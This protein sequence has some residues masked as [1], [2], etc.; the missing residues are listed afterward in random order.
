M[1]TKDSIAD[2][3]ALVVHIDSGNAQSL[4]YQKAVPMLLHK[5]HAVTKFKCSTSRK[6]YWGRCCVMPKQI[7][8]A[9]DL[10]GAWQALQ[11]RLADRQ[12]SQHWH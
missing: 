4:H 6:Y 11:L 2:I 5:C 3:R 12:S 10:L 1:H 7:D 8:A 9:V